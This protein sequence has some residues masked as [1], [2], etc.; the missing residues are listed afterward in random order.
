[1][2]MPGHKRN[3]EDFPWLARLRADWDITEIDGF[4]N[5]NDAEEILLESQQRGG[6]PVGREA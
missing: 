5:L 1:M 2:H 4:D 6:R 3:M